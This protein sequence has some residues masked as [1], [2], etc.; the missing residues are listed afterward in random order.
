MYTVGLP[1]ASL[2]HAGSAG[3]G[4]NP[5][6]EAGLKDLP[7]HS[8]SGSM[9]HLLLISALSTLLASTAT[10]QSPATFTVDQAASQ[11]TFSGSTSLGPIVGNP[12]NFTLVGACNIIA[13]TG[14]LPIQT[15]QFVPGE[16][17]L[18][19][20]DLVAEIPNPVPFLPALATIV[21]SNLRLELQSNA[22]SVNGGSF[23]VNLFS[24]TV[25]GT[26]TIT[27]LG[28]SP[29]VG[30]LTGTMSTPQPLNGTI[31]ANG[32]TLSLNA[33]LQLNFQLSDPGSGVTADFDVQGSLVADYTAPAPTSYCSSVANSSGAAGIIQA[34]GS[35]SLFANSLTL[36]ASN[37]PTLSLGYFI[38]SETQGFSTGLGGGQGNLCLSGGI[39]R[40]SNFI[41][42]SGFTGQV[43]FPIPFSGLPSAAS[44]NAG[45]SWNFQYW[46]RDASG[47]AAT[48]NTT[49]AVS[50]TFLP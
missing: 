26:S 1:T 13:T 22:G 31:S 8:R 41:Q 47:G 20:P 14:G 28:G 11:F 21:I 39:F 10:A 30:D 16:S 45:E 44:I 25:S 5:S 19:T 35:Q 23:V 24:T 9:R 7:L 34:S 4:T 37:L 12:P 18:V 27:P 2:G 42:S 43:N 3:D 48:S 33:P 46:F 49:D 15:I 36:D 50:V 38:F 17:V 29:S 32:S 40:L 6:S